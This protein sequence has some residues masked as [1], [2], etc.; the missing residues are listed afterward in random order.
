MAEAE[1]ILQYLPD[2]YRI[3]PETSLVYELMDA[4]GKRLQEAEGKLAEVMKTHWVDYV[5]K[6]GDLARIAAL[7]GVKPYDD[8]DL[9]EFRYRLKLIINAYLA[10]AG[11]A[12][13]ILYLTA[14]TLRLRIDTKLKR[15][16]EFVTRV[17]IMRDAVHAIFGTDSKT[18]TG[19]DLKAAR[20]T[21]IEHPGG[22][23]DLSSVRYIKLAIDGQRARRIDCAGEI[24]ERTTLDEIC[25][26]ISAEFEGTVFDSAVSDESAF[27]AIA[28]HDGSRITII[29]PTVGD[30]SKVEFQ[31]LV[32]GDAVTHIF[33]V[34]PD[35]TFSGT[36]AGPATLSGE[37]EP[38]EPLDLSKGSIIRVSVDGRLKE[39]DVAGPNPA[40]TTVDHIRRSINLAFGEN[41]ASLKIASAVASNTFIAVSSPLVGPSSKLEFH[42]P[43]T[44]DATKLI[45]G[46]DPGHTYTGTDATAA[47]IQGDVDLSQPVDLSARRYVRLRIDFEVQE[48]DIAGPNPEATTLNQIIESINRAF[49][50]E[51]ATA[52]DDTFIKI[53]SPTLGM[54]SQIDFQTPEDEA[55]D[56]TGTVFGEDAKL[57]V[58]IGTDPEPARCISSVSFGTPRD[59]SVQKFIKLGVDNKV[60]EIDV[61]GPD[62]GA[63]TLQQVM[64]KINRAF[65]VPVV[66]NESVITLTSGTKGSDSRIEIQPRYL[67]VVEHPPKAAKP[68]PR[69][70]KS[71]D[72]WY[73]FNRSVKTE[74]PIVE[75]LSTHGVIGPTILNLSTRVF[76]RALVVLSRGDRL[77]LRRDARLG[78][79]AWV[80]DEEVTDSVRINS[81][82]MKVPFEGKRFLNGGSEE[83]EASLQL[84]NPVLRSVVELRA[85]SVGA[86]G[87][88]ISVEIDANGQKT[89]DVKLV[90][91]DP[92]RSAIVE[93]T[94][95]GVSIGPTSGKDSLIAGINERSD[96]VSAFDL[97][98][99]L[100][101]GKSEWLYT[102]SPCHRFNCARFDEAAYCKP[103]FL[104]KGIFD[105]SE[106]GSGL[107][108]GKEGIFANAF[109][110]IPVADVRFRWRELQPATIQ[111]NLPFGTVFDRARF[112]MDNFED[113]DTRK[114]RQ[115]VGW[116]ITE[117]KAAG[118]QLSS[119]SRIDC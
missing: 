93:E 12:R 97:T 22:V 69:S 37:I 108:E 62:P 85:R 47:T 9:D 98:L 51:V 35:S 34:D 73:F 1:R 38:V 102:D 115:R 42:T 40:Q 87:N 5:D 57:S 17:R 86:M 112:D 15:P 20:V 95:R 74:T 68:A 27:N 79:R 106:F 3:S 64:D 59:L 28:T 56:A 118:V 109:C 31:S 55:F 94:Y 116:A 90:L 58:S 54:S 48:I 101:K 92:Q 13:G 26:K 84:V 19:I 71:N 21:G 53:T 7:Y 100:P 99:S 50:Y 14:A 49:K 80:N 82:G 36:N 4:F 65:A 16:Q 39:I 32:L 66:S 8:E 105:A 117:M 81:P 41:V 46:I 89:F 63:T 67:E 96:L 25:T 30:S 10:G 88:R 104:A 23:V 2:I 70:V 18:A 29:S 11:T 24:P 75:I 107:V 44:G 91:N 103:R 114:K 45:F 72:R 83:K 76:V 119:V 77:K 43:T 111:I 61:S 33:G 60:M 113:A 78:L 52:V 110:P 6:M